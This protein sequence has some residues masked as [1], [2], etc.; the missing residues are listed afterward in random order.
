LQ[1]ENF[2]G[3]SI[4][5][6]NRGDAI[7]TLHYPFSENLQ[8]SFGRIEN[9]HGFD[10]L[11]TCSTNAGSAGSPLLNDDSKVVGIHKTKLANEN[12]NIATKISIVMYA[13]NTLYN[14]RNLIEMEKA[15]QLPKE[16]SEEEIDELRNHG[17]YKTLSPQLFISSKFDY[18]P[19]LLFYRTNHAWYWTERS[20]IFRK[21]KD[22][23]DINKLKICKWSIIKIINE[24]E[25]NNEYY[26]RLIHRQKNIINFLKSTK[27]SYLIDH[28]E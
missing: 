15:K 18:Y 3:C 9:I 17:L 20:E 13:I 4:N 12:V 10:Y 8:F 6:C 16:L 7:L 22:F 28:Q 23:N 14:N 2:L 27:L 21:K 19:E 25:N 5:D 24:N 26:E 11:H 1:K